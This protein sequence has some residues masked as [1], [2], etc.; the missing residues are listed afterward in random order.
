ML[1]PVNQGQGAPVVSVNRLS[2]PLVEALIRDAQQLRLGLIP[3]PLNSL[4]IDAGIGHKGGL[5]A[6]RRIAE[7]TMGG[8]GSVT[9]QGN[10][11]ASTLRVQ[12]QTSQPVLSCLASQYAGWSLSAGEGKEKF[13]SLGSGP[14]RALACKEPLFAELGYRD[15]ADHLVLVLETDRLPP[16]AVI[17]KVARDTG[18][19]TDQLVF[20]MT[21]TA[22]LAGTTQVVARVVEVALHKA[23]SLH[24]PLEAI[25]D[26]SGHAP[27]PPAGGDFLKAMGRTNDAI[28]YGGMVH[29]YV[30]CEDEAAQ[31]LA[32]KLPSS[33][34][35]HYGQPFGA[36]FK[37]V[38][39][40]FYQLDAELFAPAQALVTNLKT[41][42]TWKNGSHN[43]AVLAQSFGYSLP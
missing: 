30:E 18:L 10:L 3:G 19:P 42:R 36:L 5:E 41:G 2:R 6:G 34:S 38:N 26:A 4:L 12:V 29:L 31:E 13:H 23:H 9:L 35:K 22:S 17:E 43:S 7:I 27:L 14:G 32:Q 33:N 16:E 15:Q 28:L 24:F 1:N 37:A 11:E 21:P 40:D 8:L 39:Y 25:V 20:I